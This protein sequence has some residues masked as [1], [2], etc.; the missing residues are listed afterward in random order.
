MDAQ[1]MERGHESKLPFGGEFAHGW[2]GK[3][4]RTN[5]RNVRLR[6]NDTSLTLLQVTGDLRR[7]ALH[8][9]PGSRSVCNDDA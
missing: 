2:Q 3:F 5:F 7:Y 1:D 8:V 9:H 4:T 6:G